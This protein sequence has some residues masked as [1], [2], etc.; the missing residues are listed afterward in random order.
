MSNSYALS[1]GVGS[2]R[3]KQEDYDLP[4]WIHD[5]E[6]AE[7]CLVLFDDPRI[8]TR[9]LVGRFGMLT[10]MLCPLFSHHGMYVLPLP[11]RTLKGL[12]SPASLFFPFFPL[13]FTSIADD[14]DPPPNRRTVSSTF[15]H[16]LRLNGKHG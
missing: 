1:A 8:D 13:A 2:S 3:E 14:V 9:R 7:A 10:S 6:H 12:A 15:N 4:V 5:G 11:S 16:P